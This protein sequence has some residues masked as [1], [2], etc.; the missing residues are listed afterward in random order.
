MRIFAS[1]VSQ[2]TMFVFL[3]FHEHMEFIHSLQFQVLVCWLHR[4]CYLG[5]VSVDWFPS[6][7][8][9][10]FSCLLA[11]LL[12]AGHCIFHIVEV[13]DFVVFF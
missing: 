10:V 4:L 8:C 12:D 6:W 9:V 11:L 7:L 1:L 13:L 5:S 3:Y 2:L